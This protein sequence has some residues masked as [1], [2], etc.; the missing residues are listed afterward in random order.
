[1]N[2]QNFPKIFGGFDLLVL[3]PWSTQHFRG[4]RQ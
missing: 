2:V 1:M 4:F 3:Y